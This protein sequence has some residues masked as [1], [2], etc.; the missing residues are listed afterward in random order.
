MWWIIIV[1]IAFIVIKIVTEGNKRASTVTKQGGMRIKYSTLIKHFLDGDTNAKI[2]QESS[3]SI[4]IGVS[5]SSGSTIFTIQQLDNAVCIV[6]KV[7]N[8]FLGNHSLKWTFNEFLEQSK[9][10]TKIEN[11]LVAYQNNVMQKYK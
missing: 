10:I 2:L 8:I 3:V 6:W 9:M 5:G 4:S 11:D 1:I 7:N